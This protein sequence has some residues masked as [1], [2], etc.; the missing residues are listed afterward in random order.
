MTDRKQKTKRRAIAAILAAFFGVLSA[1]VSFAGEPELTVTYGYKNI[2][3]SGMLLPVEVKVDVPSETLSGGFAVVEI[4]G[5]SGNISFTAP[6]EIISGTGTVRFVVTIPYGHAGAEGTADRLVVH[7]L[8]EDGEELAV[9]DVAVTYRGSGKDAFLGLVSLDPRELSWL[10]HINLTE[11]IATRTAVLS[12]GDLPDSA[13]GL[14]QL[15]LMVISGVSAGDIPESSLRAVS[16]WVRDGGT[17]ILGTGA[18]EDPFGILSAITGFTAVGLPEIRDVDLGMQYSVSGPDGAVRTLVVRQ[19]ECPDA[20]VLY[21]TEDLPVWSRLNLGSGSILVTAYDLCDLNAFGTE[22]PDYAAD[23]FAAALGRTGLRALSRSTLSGRER[24]ESIAGLTNYFTGGL[25]DRMAV[26]AV[27]AVWYLAIAG[28]VLYLFL[29]KKGLSLYYSLGV[30]ACAI[31]GGF[32]I[33]FVSAKTRIEKPYINYAA[34]VETKNGEAGADT[35]LFLDVR[36]PDLMPITLSAPQEMTF[37]PED[38]SGNVSISCGKTKM[39][40]ITGQKQFD[41]NLYTVSGREYTETASLQLLA[42]AGAD[43]VTVSVRNGSEETLHDA[44]ALCYD[45]MYLFGD[46]G[47]GEMAKAQEVRYCPTAMSAVIADRVLSDTA[48]PGREQKSALL[49]FVLEKKCGGYFDTAILFAFAESAPGLLTGTGYDLYGS[50]V[51][52]YDAGDTAGLGGGF[53]KSVLA[54]TPAVISG[55]Y[56]TATNTV[57]CGGQTVI[58]YYL[59]SEEK[60]AGLKMHPLSGD[61]VTEDL[62]P[63]AGQ[64]AVYN[65]QKSTYEPVSTEKTEYGPDEIAAW[66]SPSN[67]CLIRYTPGGDPDSGV[68]MFLPVPEIIAGNTPAA[69]EAGGPD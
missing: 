35:T 32:V 16:E 20:E 40:A 56:D 48:L 49:K 25:K 58:E 38:A 41:R 14:S 51:R 9:K 42:E 26:Y 11:E 1:F 61:M 63:F 65:Y 27:I 3:R 50:L 68:R 12:V 52:V 29:K 28:G 2:A 5:G 21:E 64:M 19:V 46:V 53:R 39:L 55:S 31:I 44:F 24:Q 57:A 33:W 66:L 22:H 37:L 23:L 15:D 8:N 17:L 62:A 60:I 45:R 34:C 54:Q 6:V 18:A 59:G 69:E 36:R 43:G 30:I 13:A 10:D 67:S 7:F 4:P 47:P